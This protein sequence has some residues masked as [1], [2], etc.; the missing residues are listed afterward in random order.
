MTNSSNKEKY[1]SMK[2]SREIRQLRCAPN[3]DHNLAQRHCT[4]IPTELITSALS[5][6][7]YILDGNIYLTM[8]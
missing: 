3:Y 2:I 8:T 5:I 7:Y 4:A 1:S 6:Y